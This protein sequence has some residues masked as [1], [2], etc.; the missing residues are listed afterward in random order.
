MSDIRDLVNGLTDKNDE[1]AYKCR[2]KLQ[3]LSEQNNEVYKYFDEFADMLDNDK[4]YIRTRGFILISANARWDIDCRIDEIID[5]YLK[6]INDIKPITA[7]QCIQ[8]L[9]NLAKHKPE[10]KEDIIKALNKVD[11]S[12]YADS[13]QSVVYKDVRDS[14]KLIASET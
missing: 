8:A 3:L 14:L 11:V 5:K 7:R 10:L 6:R 12:I 13:M 2:Q 9:P 1:N 4:S